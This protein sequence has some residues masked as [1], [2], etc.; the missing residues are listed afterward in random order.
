M[1]TIPLPLDSNANIGDFIEVRG[2]NTGGWR[3]S[4]P[5]SATVIHG[6]TNTTTGTAGS[7]SST[8][9]YDSVRIEKI[10]PNEWVIIQST[11]TLSIV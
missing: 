5:E 4:Q 7:V 10:G 11:G 2:R 3:L 6:T 1:L 8:S 9:Q